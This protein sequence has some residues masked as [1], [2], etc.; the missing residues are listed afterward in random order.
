M[1]LSRVSF[2]L[3]VAA[4]A[5]AR[6]PFSSSAPR[7]DKKRILM[8]VCDTGG[9]HRASGEALE[10]AVLAQRPKGDVDVK[11]LDIWTE[12]GVWPYN[13]MAAGYPFLCKNPWMWRTSYH[14]SRFCEWPWMV[15]TRLRNG[16][17]FKQCIAD[18]SPDLVVSL[19]PL[20]QHLPLRILKTLDK[21]G[22]LDK[23]PFATVCTDLGSA[24]PSWFV[25]EV[26]AAFVPTDA[27]RRVAT[28]RGLKETQIKQY[29]LP[30][31]APFWKKSDGRLTAA[32]SSKL[33]SSLG[34]APDKKTVLVV[35]GGDGVGSLDKIVEATALQLGQDMPNEAQV[36]AIC[37]KNKLVAKQ[38]EEKRSAWGGVQV[39][40]RG[41]TPAISDYM[42]AAHCL[43]TKAGPGTIA[44]AAIRGLP[45]MLSSHLPGQ[46]AGNVPYVIESGF[47][48]FSKQPKKIAS[49]VSDWLQDDSTLKAKSAAALQVFARHRHTRRPYNDHPRQRSETTPTPHVTHATAPS[50]LWAW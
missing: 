23:P 49:T 14:F 16:A 22:T 18:Y 37:G 42:E 10:A 17:K 36:V 25:K 4:A 30:V 15:E 2:L 11:I 13:K 7:S 40:V 35:G 48:E 45:T 19:H 6:L 27:V 21:E 29:G 8:L 47:G 41:F 34:L 43:I 46:E 20:T 50:T 39:E 26:D 12:H 28:S 24:H 1:L 31:R 5:A 38:L 33:K 44:E 32:P 3:C 9:G